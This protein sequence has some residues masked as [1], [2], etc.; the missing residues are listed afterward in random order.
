MAR[1]L[2]HGETRLND[3][4]EIEC[5][6]GT[7]KTILNSALP[8]RDGDGGI[9]GA[10]VVN[11]DITERRRTEDA[12][13]RAHDRF[14][15]L[16]ETAGRLL[17]SPAPQQIVNDLCRRVMEHLDCHVFFN[18]LVD[19]DAGRLHLNA[20]AGIPD[21]TAREIEW[22]D[23]GVAVCGCVARDGC[24]LVVE[25][26][27]H[28]DDPRADLVRSFGVQA[29]AC[30]PL[31]MQGKVIGTLSFGSRARPAF[32]EEDLSLMKMVADQV[33]M[34]MER[35]RLLEAAERRANEAE[36]AGEALREANRRKDEFLA[37][38]SHEL[39]NPLAA[40]SGAVQFLRLRG[41][42][43]PSLN[44][45]TE[46][47]DRQVRHMARL[48][49][50]LLDVARVTRGK[51]TLK[52]QPVDLRDVVTHGLQT[53]S[54]LLQ[55]RRHEVVVDLAADPLPLNADPDRLAQVVANLLS[56]AAR[57]TPPEGGI[58]LHAN[59]DGDAAVLAERDSGQG[60]PT[61]LLPHVFDLFVQGERA[62]DRREGGLGIGLTMVRA[63]VEMHAGTVEAFS[64]GAGQG[65][66]FVVR[67][68]L[69]GSGFGVQ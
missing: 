27:Q 57:Y 56:N 62:L 37:M 6:D 66:E 26:I 58:S 12:I 31:L 49:D 67:L 60:I 38:L 3:V 7:R 19:E 55:E 8:V 23:L 32:A 40:I 15:I 21:G 11:E 69:E 44:R 22:L 10:V 2:T 16:S 9:L 4:I 36:A 28:S 35:I 20:C 14:E 34:A 30:H 18:F 68:P 46:A 33:A 47:A 48:L 41:L 17:M 52:K 51:V 13:R 53:A 45:A 64:G 61:D 25:D 1:A 43:D 39:R 42:A 63:L 29:Y 65:S 24:R 5:F 54:S 50:D 59:R